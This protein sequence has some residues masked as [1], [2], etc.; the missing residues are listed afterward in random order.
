MLG[1][2]SGTRPS[3]PNPSRGNGDRGARLLDDAEGAFG[4]W[5]TNLDEAYLFENLEKYFLLGGD[6][7]CS[8]REANI[9]R[10][11]PVDPPKL[12]VPPKGS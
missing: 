5:A 7:C 1:G 9:G 10:L 12:K 3:W 6:W 4:G 11:Y 2:S 8:S